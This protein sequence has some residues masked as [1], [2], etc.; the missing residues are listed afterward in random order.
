MIKIEMLYPEI[1]NLFGD[2]A[3]VKYLASCI[4]DVKVIN[5]H[6]TDKPSFL[7][8]D[9]DF[10][11]MGSMTEKSQEL[12]IERLKPYT[13]KIKE[14]IDKNK[15]M[16][17]TGNAVEILGNYI[18]KDDGSKIEALGILNFYAK[19]QMM[20][21]VNS[22]I[23]G[24]FEIASEKNKENSNVNSNENSEGNKEN[25][26]ENI[27]VNNNE[28]SKGNSNEN[29]KENSNGNSNVNS[30]E[31]SNENSDEN[32]DENLKIVGFKS[33][34]T[35]AHGDNSNNY[36]I[37]IERGFG[38]DKE[39]KLEGFKVNNL[40]ATYLLGPILPLNPKFTKYILKLLNQKDNL[41]F[42][43]EAMEAYEIR[44]K[45]FEDKNVKG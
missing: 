38:L 43:K 17:F 14:M 10:I 40:F 24:E 9:V 42:E 13:E 34:F 12:V 30:K 28:N 7:N 15:V 41:K 11:Y 26:K 45:E 39:S 29:S 3:N 6:L 23:L 18:E 22:L 32:S 19:R 5:T 25:S 4:E 27:N 20:N 37:K 36:F 31:N 16:L 33:Q 44:L 1:C 21:R 8:E 2:Y 35:L